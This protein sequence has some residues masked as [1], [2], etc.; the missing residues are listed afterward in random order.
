MKNKNQIIN[1]DRLKLFIERVEEVTS[2][3]EDNGEVKLNEK[4]NEIKNEEI[5]YKK[6]ED[7]NQLL[8]KRMKKGKVEY[9]VNFN[10]KTKKLQWL[11]LK[12]IQNEKIKK[13]LKKS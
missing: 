10:D 4:N 3:I 11:E 9:K 2:E 8:D 6:V 7:I 1:I 12:E 13:I 5:E